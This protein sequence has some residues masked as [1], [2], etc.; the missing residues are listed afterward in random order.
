MV[1]RRTL[2]LGGTAAAATALAFSRPAESSGGHSPY[3]AGLNT[4]LRKNG[5]DRPVLLID[6]DRLDRNIDRVIKS[7]KTGTPRTFRIV[8]KSVPSPALIDYIAKR[9]GTESVMVFHR[10]F[11]Q[12]LAQLRPQ[13]DLL[14][15]KPMPV[16][17][18]D[19][20]Y[21]QHKGPFDPSRQ[22][23]WLVDS[24]ARLAQYLQWAKGQGQRLR[25]NL[26]IDVG[27]HRGGF[28]GPAAAAQ[29]LRVIAANPEQ[30]AFSGFMGYDAHIMGLPGMLAQRE[31]PK[32]KARYA[33][34]VDMLA[35]EFPQLHQ[36][37]LTFN[38]A[39]SPTFRHHETGSH[40]NDISVG[41]ALL[42]PSHYDLPVLADFEPAAFIATPV[43]KR[44]ANTG[45]PTME[46]LS[47]PMVAWNSNSADILFA[48][49]GNWLADPES[50]AGVSKAGLYT[51]SNQEG[52]LAAK[53][54]TLAPDDF[55]FLRPTQS[56]AVLLQFGDLVGIR[57]GK[58]E[59]RWPVLESHI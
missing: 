48:Y 8:A 47:G 15:G 11:I 22:L 5:I 13:S 37:P 41:T 10:P 44:H 19:T 20:F 54:V 40:L 49:G 38:G 16:A 14:L 6:L 51:S 23:Q 57:G 52:Y 45:V 24:D 4:L 28:T 56:E 50:P 55:L 31:V 21:K 53:G 34:F 27:L 43:L 3:F 29:V 12:E 36:G 30:L 1:S 42:K 35:R 32:V 33:A 39:G 26:E 25:I 58:V 59:C 2:L 7:A 46:W 18:V 17:A 9:A